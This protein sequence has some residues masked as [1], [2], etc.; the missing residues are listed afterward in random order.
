MANRANI[1]GDVLGEG[2]KGC[3]PLPLPPDPHPQSLEGLLKGRKVGPLARL[4]G[5]PSAGWEGGVG[6]GQGPQVPGPPPTSQLYLLATVHGDPAGYGRVW[7]F[8]EY[9]RPEVITVEISRF[10]VRYRQRAGRDW[11]RRLSGALASLPP[12]TDK[13]LAVARL[14]AQ[15]ALP[16]EYRAARD[17]GKVQHIP[18]KLLDTG[19]VARRH[20]PRYADQFLT[21]ENLRLLRE[22]GPAGTLEAFVIQE[23]HRARLALERKLK[24]IP[25]PQVAEDGSRERLWAKRLRRLAAKEKRVVHVGGWEHLVPWPDGGGLPHLLADLKPCI[26][27]LDEAE[28]IYA[29]EEGRDASFQ[30]YC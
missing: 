4:S 22:T 9:V 3:K 27:L 17:W 11:R 24:R 16:Y 23:F 8:F 2:A 26:M 20:L 25:R 15:I 7:R 6:G 1:K 29:K 30:M 21:T 18:V 14:A 19:V 12:D 28:K 10:S 5:I 13:N